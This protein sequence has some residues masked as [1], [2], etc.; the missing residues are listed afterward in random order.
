MVTC[1]RCKSSDVQR[2]LTVSD[3][4]DETEEGELVTTILDPWT[5]PL[6]LP[7]TSDAQRMLEKWAS[8]SP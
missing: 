6:C 8:T 7:C 1:E 2:I 5:M 3:V 4:M